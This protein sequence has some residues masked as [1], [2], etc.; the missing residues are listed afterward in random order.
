MGSGGSKSTSTTK[1]KTTTGKSTT[2]H[3]TVKFTGMTIPGDWADKCNKDKDWCRK[4]IIEIISHHLLDA[5]FSKKVST[6]KISKEMED[7]FREECEHVSPGNVDG[8]LASKMADEEVKELE[9]YGVRMA[10]KA[11]ETG[12]GTGALIGIVVAVILFTMAVIGG[13]FCLLSGKGSGDKGGGGGGRKSVRGGSIR[14]SSKSGSAKKPSARKLLG[15]SGKKSH[16]S[17]KSGSKKSSKGK[18][19]KKSLKSGSRKSAKKH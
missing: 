13:L 1:K 3:S 16:K 6:V 17:L 15:K 7:K 14:K 12:L 18:S 10:E 11:E 4:F 9:D 19:L 5:L 2:P 8:C